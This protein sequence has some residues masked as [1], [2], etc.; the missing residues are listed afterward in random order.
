MD[1]TPTDDI[2]HSGVHGVGFLVTNEL[3]WKFRPQYESDYGIDAQV[4]IV[5]HNRPLGQLLALQ[6]KAGKSWFREPVASPRGWVFRPHQRH[7]EYWLNHDLPVLVVLFDED[8]YAAYWQQVTADTIE[9]TRRGAHKLIVPT[10]N[11][12]DRSAAHSLRDV[13]DDSRAKRESRRRQVD[14]VSHRATIQGSLSAGR[15]DGRPRRFNTNDAVVVIPGFSG[16]ELI[17]ID[18]GATVWGS[19]NIA[20]LLRLWTNG[21]AVETLKVTNGERSGQLRLAASRLLGMPAFIPG[22]HGQEPYSKLVSRARTA[23][24]RPDAVLEFPYDWRLG[25]AHNAALLAIA[26]ERHLTNWRR[27]QIAGDDAELVLVA[28]SIGGLVAQYFTGIL[29]GRDIVRS[30]VTL[31]TP[32]YGSVASVRM[33]SEGLRFPLP[34][35]YKRAAELFRTMPGLYDMLPTYR[36]VDDGGILRTL[37]AADIASIGGSAELASQAFELH[38]RLCSSDGGVL[39]TIVGVGQPTAQSVHIKSGT[40]ELA[41]YARGPES[42]GSLRRVDTK[43]DSIVIPEAATRDGAN[44]VYVS[45]THGALPTSAE[46][47]TIVH[48]EISRRHMDG[49][50]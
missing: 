1:P 50:L 10:S 37:T 31:G 16:S 8:K 11:R 42:A 9:V 44:L 30:T 14:A 26:A 41:N 36:C 6:I 35:P 22:F 48:E 21:S 24:A 28:H 15:R 40:I 23:A 12:L 47:L 20:W 29:G 4:E 46:A 49:L 18:S 2:G 19:T 17:D 43:G 33:L 34:L 3:R 32:F 13:V 38:Q 27:Q 25:V 45:Q 5:E 7:L 39:N